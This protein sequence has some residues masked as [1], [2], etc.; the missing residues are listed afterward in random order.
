MGFTCGEKCRE[1]RYYFNGVSLNFQKITLNAPLPFRL[2]YFLKVFLR[3]GNPH[4]VSIAYAADRETRHLMAERQGF[5]PWRPLR[6]CRFSRPVHST[7]LPSLR[8]YAAKS[9]PSLSKKTALI[10]LL[11]KED[12]KV[13]LN[14]LDTIT[15]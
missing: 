9:L 6:A 1:T 12:V 11:F 14:E 15:G 7:T 3:S 4:G 5:E 8:I 13:N 10:L 2:S